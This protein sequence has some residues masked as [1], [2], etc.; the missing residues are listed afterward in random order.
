[1][2]HVLAARVRRVDLSVPVDGHAVQEVLQPSRHVHGEVVGGQ[3]EHGPLVGDGAGACV[4]V[5][6]QDVPA[7][8]VDQVHD[9]AVRGPRDAV[10]DR[11][12]LRDKF[13]LCEVPMRMFHSYHVLDNL[14][15]VGV[16]FE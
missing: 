13:D 11:V 2:T 7:P 5:P 14:A 1:M 6:R 15:T 10:A 12:G 3:V 8:A 9:P 16:Q 4:E